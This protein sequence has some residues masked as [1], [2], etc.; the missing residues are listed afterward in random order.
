[1]KTLLLLVST[2]LLSQAQ[3]KVSFEQYKLKNGL[4]VILSR[5]NAVPAVATYLIYDIGSRS[6]EKGR[7]GF[8]HLFEHMMFQGTPNAPKG[9]HMRSIQAAGGTLNAS[10]HPDYTDYYQVMPSNKL[11]LVL[12]L[13]ADRMRS[14]AIN[15]E[16]LKNQIAAV[17]EERRMRLENQPYMGAVFERWPVLAYQNWHNQTSIIGTMEDLSA[18]TTDDVRSFFKTYYAP[19]N[20]VL[21][22]V[23][24]I[25]P[26]ETKKMIETYFGDIPAQ[27]QPKAPD[28]T[29]PTLKVDSVVVKD[30]LARVPGVIAGY[31]GPKRRSPDYYAMVM[32]DVL[33]TGGDSSRFQQRLV[34]GKE[35]VLQYQVD[36]GWPFRDSTDYKDPDRYAMF[37]LHKPN[38]TGKQ[39]VAQAQEI[40]D[41]IAAKGV[42][43]EELE[44]G[45]TFFRAARIN[46]MQSP[47]SRAEL[48]GKFAVL[49]NDPNLVNTDMQTYMAV[50]SARIQAFAKEYLRPEKQFVLEIVPA[51]RGPAPPA[52]KKEGE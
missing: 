8:A 39:I 45:R 16:N 14:L 26:A 18:S 33:L 23:G 28:L 52:K 42:P 46:S 51:P 13:E 36:A 2:A 25:Q 20:A 27:P 30:P 9:Y 1:M 31:P 38:Y 50:T 21:V 43:A 6:E 5:D 47:L 15:P 32:L 22:I 11:P 29:E 12:W 35:S 24:D 17:Q 48:L 37:L 44:R 49:D 19:N 4:R 3:V 34:K 7:T 10:T 41:E 40:I